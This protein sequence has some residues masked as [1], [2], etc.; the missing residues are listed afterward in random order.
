L[1][2]QL[3][4]LTKGDLTS[5]AGEAV[6]KLLDAP[7]PRERLEI[8]RYLWGANF[9]PALEERLAKLAYD[10]DRDV[11]YYTVYS[12]LSTQRN[13]GRRCVDV[14]IERLGNEDWYNVGGRAI[15]GLGYGVE[16]DQQ[17]RVADAAL[18]VFQSRTD[19]Y[20]RQQSLRSLS[21][22]GRAEQVPALQ[23]IASKPGISAELQTE[24][25]RAI[26]AMRQR[27]TAK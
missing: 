2:G 12:A 22:Y 18:K 8:V 21:T 10:P 16:P 20:L 4:W 7:D 25:G 11:S 3:F 17:A 27:T 26:S 9:S 15:W 5:R 19:G 24:I 1:A 13:K 14:L 6:L 23:E